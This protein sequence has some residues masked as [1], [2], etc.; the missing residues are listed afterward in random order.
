MKRETTDVRHMICG[1]SGNRFYHAII[2]VF[3]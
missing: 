1:F 2:P 3:F